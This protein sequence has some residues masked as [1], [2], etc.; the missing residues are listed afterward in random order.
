FDLTGRRVI[1]MDTL[2]LDGA[3]PSDTDI[4]NTIAALPADLYERRS[5]IASTLISTGSPDP[6]MSEILTSRNESGA[7]RKLCGD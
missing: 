7:F 5:K 6:K 3:L 4:V 1:L 2:G